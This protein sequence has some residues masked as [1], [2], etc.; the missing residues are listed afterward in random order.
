MKMNYHLQHRKKNKNPFKK[1]IFVVVF[2]LIVGYFFGGLLTRVLLPIQAGMNAVL[3]YVFPHSFRSQN[4]I[5]TENKELRK[6]IVELEASQ[7]ELPL[8][9]SQNTN[10]KFLLGRSGDVKAKR[11]LAS[12]L[13]APSKT[14]FDILLLDVGTNDGIVVDDKIF[15]GP[16]AI[17]KI[18]EVSTLY[19]KAML[20]SAPQN[21]FEGRLNEIQ[22][23]VEGQGGGQFESLVPIGMK[24]E[25]GD[26]LVLPALSPKVFGVVTVIEKL[27]TEGFKKILFSL[28]VNPNQIT[29]VTI[30]K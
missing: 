15:V 6:R 18:V 11:I 17:G 24:V 7:L 5:E 20:F 16:L 10:L 3:L 25:V 30:E 9:K 21:K 19:S 14:P 8:L 2:C 12:V 26:S 1:I 29:E 28:P 23:E 22:I 27:E 4:T 13:E